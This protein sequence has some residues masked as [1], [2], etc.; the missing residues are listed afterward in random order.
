MKSVKIQ[1]RD[2]IMV[3]QRVMEFRKLYPK[4]RISTSIIERTEDY[5][6]MRAEVVSEDNIVIADGYAY[7][8]RVG[9]AINKFK[10]VENCQTSAIGRALGFLGIGIDASIASAEEI[11][12][13]LDKE[14]YIKQTD[15]SADSTQI[16]TW[17]TE[18]Q[19]KYV[20]KLIEAGALEDAKKI[21]DK[22]SKAPY[23]MKKAWK[24][25]LLNKIKA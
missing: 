22:Y 14:K 11:Q 5:I 23:G 25:E 1:G 20:D 3:H 19:K 18:E 21:I 4:W 6:L 8:V 24:E 16:T 17:L 10:Y 12:S 15:G 13:V 9:S 7:E 2:Y